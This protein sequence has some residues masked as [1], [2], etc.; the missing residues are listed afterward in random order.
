MMVRKSH[1]CS[2]AALLKRDTEC[3]RGF[4]EILAR[5]GPEDPVAVLRERLGYRSALDR[6]PEASK[7]LPCYQ[8]AR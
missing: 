3:V 2:I 8:T 4:G 6:T 7:I 1:L 5:M